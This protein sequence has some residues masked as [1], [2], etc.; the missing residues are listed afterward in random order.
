MT[1]DRKPWLSIE[2]KVLKLIEPIKET[3]L[4]FEGL[5]NV[6]DKAIPFEKAELRSDLS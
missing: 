4:A 3:I 1:D 5:G 2:T 6:A